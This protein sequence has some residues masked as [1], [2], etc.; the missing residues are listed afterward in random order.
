MKIDGM[1][2]NA[3]PARISQ[4]PRLTNDVRTFMRLAARTTRLDLNRWI[5]SLP[6][7]SACVASLVPWQF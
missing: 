5:D 2:R 3:A 6:C 4:E 7:V 1:K